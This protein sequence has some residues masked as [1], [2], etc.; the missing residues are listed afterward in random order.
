MMEMH[1][2]IH[3]DATGNPL[4]SGEKEDRPIFRQRGKRNIRGHWPTRSEGNFHW[5]YWTFA[6]VQLSSR[7]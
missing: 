1:G 6:L 2:T 3:F 7:R 4:I 5:A